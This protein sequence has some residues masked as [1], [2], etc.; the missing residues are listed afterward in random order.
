MN[1]MA[2][3]TSSTEICTRVI[4]EKHLVSLP[5]TFPSFKRINQANCVLTPTD[6]A[7]Q[8]FMDGANVTNIGTHEVTPFLVTNLNLPPELR[9]LKEN[10]MLV[11]L[12]PGPRK[13]GLIDSYYWPL[14]RS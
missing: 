9:Y 14:V 7:L 1:H 2:G 3:E 5:D 10:I 8:G 4:I 12:V 11:F 6:I 13:Y